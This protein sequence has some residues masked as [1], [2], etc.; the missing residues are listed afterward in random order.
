M[1]LFLKHFIAPAKDLLS[2]FQLEIT[3]Y[4]PSQ[5]RREVIRAVISS[6]ASASRAFKS[7]QEQ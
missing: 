3:A 5:R 1:F 6:R 4:L 2:L 7:R